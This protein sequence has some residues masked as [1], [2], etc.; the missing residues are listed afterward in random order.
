MNSDLA[1][2]PRHL[3]SKRYLGWAARTWEKAASWSKWSYAQPPGS[4][5]GRRGR[6]NG[7]CRITRICY[8]C[9]QNAVVSSHGGS[10]KCR[11]DSLGCGFDADMEDS[12]GNL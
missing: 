1:A 3:S 9:V 12:Q 10:A 7:L 11:L 2:W 8:Y 6:C 5:S 4:W